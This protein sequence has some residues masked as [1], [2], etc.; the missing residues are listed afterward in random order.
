MNAIGWALVLIFGLPLTLF[1]LGFLIIAVKIFRGGGLDEKRR[2][3]EAARGL[4]RSLSALE[5]RL[6]A[7]EDI[8]LTEKQKGGPGH[9]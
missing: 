2:L 1:G 6:E 4:E 5:T 8:I 7:L 9:E 3:A